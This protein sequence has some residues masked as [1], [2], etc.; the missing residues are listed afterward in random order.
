MAVTPA[1]TASRGRDGSLRLTLPRC[2]TGAGTKRH[3][4]SVKAHDQSYLD[5]G[6]PDT[7]VAAVLASGPVPTSSEGWQIP[8]GAELERNPVPLDQRVLTG[9]QRIY[10]SKCQGRHGVNGKGDGPDADPAHAPGD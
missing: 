6:L 2:V 5:A 4:T 10:K 9:G 7:V 3:A 1:L 8:D